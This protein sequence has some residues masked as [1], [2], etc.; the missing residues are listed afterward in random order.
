MPAVRGGV[1]GQ[2]ETE[3]EGSKGSERRGMV[4]SDGPGRV[5]RN[6]GVV[7]MEFFQIVL[8]IRKICHECEQKITGKRTGRAADPMAC[9]S[10]CDAVPEH[11]SHD[12][13]HADPPPP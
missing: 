4:L 5:A 1:T 7:A 6:E 10:C 2:H 9:S 11:V 3:R 8:D 12:E 13:A